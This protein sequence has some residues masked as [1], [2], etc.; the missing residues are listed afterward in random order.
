MNVI[1]LNMEYFG[2][3]GEA[4]APGEN[5]RR[6]AALTFLSVCVVYAV[7]MEDV[8]VVSWCVVL[9]E[10]SIL[11]HLFWQQLNHRQLRFGSPVAYDSV[12]ARRN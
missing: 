11:I 8:C 5:P 4:G 2:V 12:V 10:V 3:W 9:V 1:E 6:H 7:Y